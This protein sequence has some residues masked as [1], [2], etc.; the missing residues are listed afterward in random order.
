MLVKGATGVR[1]LQPKFHFKSNQL[2]QPEQKQIKLI[3]SAG[4][5]NNMSYNLR[6]CGN[7]LRKQQVR[8]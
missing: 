4:R 2:A 6:D 7:P 3:F 1:M 5:P 8:L